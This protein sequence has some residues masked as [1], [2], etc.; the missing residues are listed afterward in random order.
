[1]SRHVAGV[2]VICQCEIV[3]LRNSGAERG[4]KS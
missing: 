3:S 2:I 4:D 1:M